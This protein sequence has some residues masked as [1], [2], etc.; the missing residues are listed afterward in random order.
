MVGLVVGPPSDPVA[1]TFCSSTLPA[2]D[3]G[4]VPALLSLA[5]GG[6]ALLVSASLAAGV[7]CCASDVSSGDGGGEVRVPSLSLAIISIIF[8]KS[9]PTKKVRT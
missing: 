8:L 6:V 3:T 4:V 9:M 5:T 7:A 1:A 2:V